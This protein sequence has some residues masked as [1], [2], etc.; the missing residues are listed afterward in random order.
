[1]TRLFR[2]TRFPRADFIAFGVCAAAALA[3]SGG[4]AR[5]DDAPPAQGPSQS[6]SS[7]VAGFAVAEVP[8][9]GASAGTNVIDLTKPDAPA[10]S[11]IHE[12]PVAGSM[13]EVPASAGK[14]NVEMT[15]VQLLP[16]VERPLHHFY[17][18][19]YARLRSGLQI[20]GDAKTWWARAE[21]AYAKLTQPVTDAVMVFAGSPRIRRG[22]VAIVTQVVSPREIRVDQA[23]W[24]NHG[25]IERA[26]PVLDVSPN[27]DWSQVR[28][29]DMP[30]GRFGVHVYE[31]K[32]FIS[33]MPGSP[34]RT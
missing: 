13:A 17:C 6:G 18:V 12:I 7:N 34:T 8:G 11:G 2:A 19:E 9:G 23:N 25:E 21:S 30:S 32:G 16:S 5:A 3:V 26:T 1:M 33:R 28:V 10:A 4:S 22:H 31:V 27:N 29:W 20:F 14:A 15:G 24:Q